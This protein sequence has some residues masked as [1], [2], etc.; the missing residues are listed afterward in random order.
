MAQKKVG[1]Q[2][3][4]LIPNH[5][6]LGITLNYVHVGGMPILLENFRQ[7]LQLASNLTSIKG[8]H[9]KLWVFK[10]VRNIISR[11][12]GLLS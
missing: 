6:K 7:G 3:V 11:I 2:D 4:N 1:S 12:V 8:L 9:K 5:Y 10:K